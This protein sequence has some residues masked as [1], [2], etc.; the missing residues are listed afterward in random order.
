MLEYCG[1]VVMDASEYKGIGVELVNN[2]RYD[3]VV[4]YIINHLKS[5]IGRLDVLKEV[6]VFKVPDGYKVRIILGEPLR[7]GSE[8]V[9][10]IIVNCLRDV[11]HSSGVVDDTTLLYFMPLA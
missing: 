8:Y 10:R 11:R 6:L 4:D 3:D 7:V 2:L 5:V 1:G 9:T